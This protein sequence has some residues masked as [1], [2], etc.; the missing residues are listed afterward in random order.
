MRIAGAFNTRIMN[1]FTIKDLE[2]LSGIKAHTI[3]IWE[4]RYGLLKPMRTPT[5][6]RFYC[7]E[8][9]KTLLNIALLNKYGFKISHIGK[10]EPGEINNKILTLADTKAIQ[11]R[12]VN[13]LVAAMVELDMNK[14]E[15]TIGGYISSRG[16]EKTVVQIIFP[17]LEKVGIL[18]QTGR[19]HP[20]QEHLV[21]NIVRQKLIVGIETT[22]SS[23]QIPKTF[24]LYLPEGEQH[25]LGLLF[26]HFI[27][28][29]R[30]ARVIYLGA[31]VPAADVAHVVKMK[32]PDIAYLHLTGTSPSFNF[33]KFLQAVHQ[34][35]NGVP[36]IISG[37]ITQQYRKKP[38]PSVQFKK[39]LGE[40]MEMLSN[41]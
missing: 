27:L 17:F 12:V 20:A 23:V 25:E 28:K 37:L 7:N 10:M 4:Q 14:F 33:E 29:S 34:D 16:I 32:Q 30:G 18:W 40:V 35:M 36:T 15:K 38:P 31:N 13:Q 6:I 5:N 9:L 26:M 2:Y 39:S 24:L 1:A 22:S 19:I 8:D 21:T 3:R 11:E 41:L